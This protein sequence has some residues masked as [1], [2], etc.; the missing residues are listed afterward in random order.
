MKKKRPRTAHFKNIAVLEIDLKRVKE[1][2]L[3]FQLLHEFK[4]LY[5]I[6][7]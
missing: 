6:V 7:G 4:I 5:S 3:Y 2:W 1:K